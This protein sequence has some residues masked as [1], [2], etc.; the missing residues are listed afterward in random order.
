MSDANAN[1]ASAEGD[2]FLE[3]LVVGQIFRSGSYVIDAEKIK[4]F[5][6]E[7]DPQPYH[8]DEDAATETFFGELVASGWH[9]ASITMRLLVSSIPI[10]GGLVGAGGEIT[11]NRPTRPGDS[12]SVESEVMEIRPSRNRSD[13]GMVSIRSITRNQN[14][15]SVQIMLSRLV[16]PSK[17]VKG[18]I[19]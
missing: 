7:F 12:L 19:P 3:D 10:K 1:F 14:G 17:N 15:K 16:V 4:A 18:S 8:L 13:R 2:I 11:W 6:G 9:T 5:A